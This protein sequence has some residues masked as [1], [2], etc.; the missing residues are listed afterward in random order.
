MLLSTLDLYRKTERNTA[1]HIDR[2]ALSVDGTAPF[3]RS[4]VGANID[5]SR[6]DW[7]MVFTSLWARFVIHEL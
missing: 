4:L 6:N 2:F 5:R 7:R 1:I 3:G